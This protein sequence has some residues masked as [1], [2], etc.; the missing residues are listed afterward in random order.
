MAGRES[1]G[2]D[3]SPESL[4]QVACE[5]KQLIIERALRSRPEGGSKIVAE[6]GS[7]DDVSQLVSLDHPSTMS[8]RAAMLYLASGETSPPSVTFL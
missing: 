4:I 1:T 3:V 7:H 8:A 6:L 2:L 5:Q